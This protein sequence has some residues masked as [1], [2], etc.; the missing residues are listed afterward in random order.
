MELL[1]GSLHASPA[2]YD[3]VRGKNEINPKYIVKLST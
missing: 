1:G 3:S 2:L